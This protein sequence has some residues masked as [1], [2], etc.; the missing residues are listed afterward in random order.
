MLG[1]HLVIMRK[2]V[3]A[4]SV[5]PALI[6]DDAPTTK[7]WFGVLARLGYGG[8]LL[9]LVLSCAQGESATT[10]TTSSSSDNPAQV[11]R[12]DSSG[13]QSFT[14]IA[15]PDVSLLPTSKPV[16]LAPGLPRRVDPKAPSLDHEGLR[17]ISLPGTVLFTSEVL[18]LPGLLLSLGEH[19]IGTDAAADS[20]IFVVRKSDGALVQRLGRKG[21]GP[22]EFRGIYDLDAITGKDHEFWAYDLPLRR[23]TLIDLRHPAAVRPRYA[24]RTMPLRVTSTVASV[25][26]LDTL[27]ATSGFYS[28][29]RIGFFN[30][31]GNLVRV[32]GNVP[33]GGDRV[34]GHVRQHAYQGSLAVG[35]Q[36]TRLA[37]LTRHLGQLELYRRDGSLVRVTSG[38]YVFEPT[39]TV[40]SSRG[41]PVMA[42]DVDLRFGYVAVAATDDLIFGLFS[43]RTREGF[44]GEASF[45]EYVHVFDWDGNLRRVFKL[46]VAVLY[47]AIDMERGTLYAVRHNPAPAIM[48]Y[49]LPSPIL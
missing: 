15:S 2:R 33:P 40:R 48:A 24:T 29:G 10:N 14:A 22:G 8:A 25:A 35:R 21:A 43:G 1:A 5:S 42:T 11:A 18:G 34:P 44:P 28:N 39:Y 20:L 37:I 36:G 17:A 47:I 23:M 30:A 9:L 26:W 7:Y 46:D 13:T 3:L 16:P 19:L 41:G 6:V 12:S 27:L 49:K 38:P 32:A 31:G 4:A 45:G